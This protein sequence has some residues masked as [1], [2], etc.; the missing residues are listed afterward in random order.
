[1]KTKKGDQDDQIYTEND[2]SWPEEIIFRTKDRDNGDEIRE[3]WM[4]IQNI[5]ESNLKKDPKKLK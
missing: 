5:K 4:K 2:F 3:R 1:M